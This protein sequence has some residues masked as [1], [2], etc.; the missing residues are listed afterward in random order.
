MTDQ[1]ALQKFASER[2]EDAFRILVE[3]YSP[4]VYSA[5][6]RTLNQ[7]SDAE[8][9]VQIVF[10]T[11]AQKA[12]RLKG[13]V[14]LSGWL[15]RTALFVAQ[16]HHLKSQRRALREEEVYQMTPK[17]NETAHESAWEIIRTQIDQAIGKLPLR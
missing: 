16:R 4:M 9:V 3:R 15:Y 10:A 13:E 6:F 2:S 17:T 11:L 8:D 7:V 5:A 14:I 1:E 12:H